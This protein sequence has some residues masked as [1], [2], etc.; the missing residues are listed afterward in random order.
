MFIDARSLADGTPIEADVCIVGSGAAGLAL[1]NELK[2]GAYRVAIVEG[3]GR[4]FDPEP[5]ALYQGRNVGHSYMPLDTC[6]TR[7]F[8]GS[9]NTWGGNCRPLDAIAFEPRPWV[10]HSGWPFDSAH[11]A[12]FYERAQVFMGL[13][14]LR[15][16]EP[17]GW[18]TERARRLPLRPDRVATGITELTGR[19]FGDV[20]GPALDSAANVRV[21]LHANVVDVETDENQRAVTGLRIARVGGVDLE[22]KGRVFILAAGGI[23]NPRL[24]LLSG[25][26]GL[27]ND[28]DL[29]GRFFME[30][31]NLVAGCFV[32]SAAD[33][34]EL[35]LYEVPSRRVAGFA[36]DAKKGRAD[37]RLSEQIQRERRLLNA[38]ATF[39]R[40]WAHPSHASEGYLALKHVYEGVI[41]GRRD[42]LWEHLHKAVR[43][44]DNISAGVH[45]KLFEQDKPL[46]LMDFRVQIEQEPNPSSRVRLSDDRDRFGKRR[47]ELDWRLTDND[48]RTL[49]ETARIMAVEC[50]ATA[51]GRLRVLLPPDDAALSALVGGAWHHMGTTR[52]HTD[53]R[54]G[55]VDENCR[56]HGIANLFVAGSSV[57]PAVGHAHPT[58]TIVALALRLANHVKRVLS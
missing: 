9:L 8:G 40:L 27:G 33:I 34:A 11:L 42:G 17:A 41:E 38:S 4:Q 14:P 45:W 23:E 54:K 51:A 58:L 10:A 31:L 56:V 36:S 48:L 46:R 13:G 52:M 20:Y 18:E 44:V 32:P 1:A 24:L 7:Y 2:G 6:R 22:V 39:S 16:Y 35:D 55:V 30:S 37:L 49:R 43:D 28:H 50:G 29:V 47:V 25:S 19:W 5:Q 26:R 3:G 53:P 15:T 12:P 57:F 21:Y